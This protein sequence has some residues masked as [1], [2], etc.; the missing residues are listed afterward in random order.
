[1]RDLITEDHFTMQELRRAYD[2]LDVRWHFEELRDRV[3]PQM[4]K[5]RIWDEAQKLHDARP[6]LREK[7]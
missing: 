7:P 3:I 5:N 2:D 6:D 1:M 4:R